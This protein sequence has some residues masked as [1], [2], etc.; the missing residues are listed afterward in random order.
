MLVTT[1]GPSRT[2]SETLPS[3][4]L[5][6]FPWLA[7]LHVGRYPRTICSCCQQNPSA[8]PCYCTLLLL[9]RA[10]PSPLCSLARE[11]FPRP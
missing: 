8:L 7:D 1:L 5:L 4:S 6:G 10:C 9:L 3:P 11:T 2:A